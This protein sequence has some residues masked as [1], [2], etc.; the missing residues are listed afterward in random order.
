MTDQPCL[1]G[2]AFCKR[3]IGTIR[4]ECL[5]WL[6]PLSERHLRRILG[7]WVVHYNRGRP[8]A[9]LGPGLREPPPLSHR[10]PASG[11]H[12][13]DRHHVETTP[14]QTGL[15]HEYRWVEAA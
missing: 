11:H 14:I 9:N 10:P 6:I 13:P 15:H 7:E 5:D 4:R 8:H 3:V 12:F 2:H 1:T